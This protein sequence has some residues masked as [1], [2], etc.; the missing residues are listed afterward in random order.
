MRKYTAK[1]GKTQYKP[2]LS[3]LLSASENNEGFCL[4]CGAEHDGV[5]SDA[6]KYHCTDCNEHK[7]YGAEE[8]ILMGLY[9]SDE[10]QQDNRT[11]H[12]Y[13]DPSTQVAA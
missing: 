9:Y 6:R 2:G 10:G 4:S 11:S 12:D 3:W 8:L 7:V 5:E 1:S 13:G